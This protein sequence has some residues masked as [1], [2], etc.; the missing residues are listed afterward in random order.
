SGD[1]TPQRIVCCSP[2]AATSQVPRPVLVP[3]AF[4]FPCQEPLRKGDRTPQ[5][6]RTAL[7]FQ[8][9]S[10]SPVPFSDS[11][12]AT[13]TSGLEEIQAAPVLD[14]RR[15]GAPTAAHPITHL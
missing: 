15:P 4:P 14:R 11:L 2:V 1:A 12:L 13:T 8:G 6:L 10:K 5:I 7:C 3:S 9:T